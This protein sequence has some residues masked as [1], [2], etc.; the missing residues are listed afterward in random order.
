MRPVRKGRMPFLSACL[1]VKNEEHNLERCLGSL[2]GAVDEVVLLDTGSTDRTVEIATAMGARVFYF[3]WCDDFSAARNESLRHARG[4]W[5]IWVDGDDE[6]L[7]DQPDALRRL[8]TAGTRTDWGY[9]VNVRSPYGPTGDQEV[10]V[11]H[12]RIFP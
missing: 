8:C 1:I 9:W 10:I 4:E 2:Q 11:R 12:W 3:E 6:L 5:I 7:M